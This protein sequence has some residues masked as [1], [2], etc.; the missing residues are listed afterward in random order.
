M[1]RATFSWGRAAARERTCSSSCLRTASAGSGGV[2][3]LE[4]ADG[5]ERLAVLGDTVHV[6][7]KNKRVFA[8]D[9]ANGSKRGG[10]V[11]YNALHEKDV[12][13]RWEM[14]EADKK[15]IHVTPM[16]MELVGEQLVFSY[17]EYDLL[18]FV[19]AKDA[20][21]AR[22]VKV[23]R[24]GG[25]AAG[26]NQTLFIASAGKILALDA[27][28]DETQTVVEDVGLKSPVGL[29]WEPVSGDLIVALNGE[30][31]QHLRRYHDGKL[32]GTLG[33]KEGRQ[34]GAF[35]SE[36][37]HGLYDVQTDGRGGFYTIEAV[38]R[39]VAHFTGNAKQ[40][41][42]KWLGP[43]H[44]GAMLAL[45]PEDPTIAFFEMEDRQFMRAKL[46]FQTKRWTLTHI[47]ERLKY[48]QPVEMGLRWQVKHRGGRTYLVN[49]GENFIRYVPFVVEVLD[50]GARLQMVSFLS[51]LS[52]RRDLLWW[53][54]AAER[55][56][57][58]KSAQGWTGASWTDA[59]GDGQIQTDEV[60]A[61]AR[62]LGHG[63]VWLDKD[64]NVFI[65]A[66]DGNAKVPDANGRATL[67]YRIPNRAAS[68]E[69]TPGWDWK[70][71]QPVK[72]EVPEEFRRW[73]FPEM[74]GIAV[75]DQG[76]VYQLTG[77]SYRVGTTPQERELKQERHTPDWPHNYGA[78]A[79]LFKW[80]SDGSLEWAVGKKANAKRVEQPGEIAVPVAILGFAGNKLFLHDRAGRVTTAWTTDGLAAGYV[81]D[82]HVDDGAPPEIIYHVTGDVSPRNFLMGDD[83]VIQ[84]WVHAKD[85]HIYWATPGQDATALYRIHDLQGG[86]QQT[87]TIEIKAAALAAQ[88]A[89]RGLK[90]EYFATP[91]LSGAHVVTRVDDQIW[92]RG[93]YFA[94]CSEIKA[95]PFFPKESPVPATEFSARWTGEVEP[96]F[97]EDYR[98]GFYYQ[99]DRSGPNQSWQGSKVRLW[100]GDQLVLDGW[101]T[102][103]EK[104]GKAPRSR[105]NTSTAIALV[106]G[107]KVPIRVEF[108]A[109]GA[110]KPHLHLYWESRT[111]D[112]EHIPAA[113]L[114]PAK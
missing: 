7:Q 93:S 103:P 11:F 40:P 81:F 26:P 70:D 78:V 47:Y 42:R 94:F 106:A 111:Q 30:G 18:R 23:P 44:W 107:R 6:L 45:D 53:P 27:G 13:W 48:P 113:A 58:N 29:A 67:W 10:K 89:G 34:W 84:N 104:K 68:I 19:S 4:V 75:D 35:D 74:R 73:G 37:F 83:H 28:R 102:L 79:R 86:T 60:R 112:R 52:E 110:E 105:A 57:I 1:R 72:A 16:D 64:F 5:V 15:R 87:G 49:C 71:A 96:R 43:V 21:L 8:L 31:S 66:G 54:Q 65:A 88:L 76:S 99:G 3:Q 24:P 39:R 92:F 109:N 62:P 17:Y 9:A 12:A 77:P 22:E 14:P 97:C 63:H 38:P 59:N 51:R 91:D 61:A 100:V 85:G 69:D 32:A 50:G 46:D 25:L 20:T 82:R 80:R 101:Q 98:L 95:P 33:R 114:Y 56:G 55:N 41:D 36:D 90:A 108:A 2:R